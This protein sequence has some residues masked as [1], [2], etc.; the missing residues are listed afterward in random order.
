MFVAG[1]WFQ[2]LW[3]YDFR[4]TEMCIIPYATQMGEISFCAYNTGVG[5]RQIVENMY[6]NATV[7]EWYK[8]HGKHAVYANP[9][10]AVPLPAGA[11]PVSLRIPRD[12]QLDRV[13]AAARPATPPRT[14]GR[15][16]PTDLRRRTGPLKTKRPADESAGLL[17]FVGASARSATR[18]LSP[19]SRRRRCAASA[20][21]GDRWRSSRSC[22]RSPRAAFCGAPTLASAPGCVR[23]TKPMT[24]SSVTFISNPAARA[25]S[26]HAST[27]GILGNGGSNGVGQLTCHP[28]HDVIHSGTSSPP[29]ELGNR[30]VSRS[31]ATA[32]RDDLAEAE[33]APEE[34][35][36]SGAKFVHMKDLQRGIAV[37]ILNA[38]LSRC[39]W[40]NP[41]HVVVSTASRHTVHAHVGR[42]R[43][44]T[45]ARRAR[46]CY[47]GGAAA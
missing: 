43:V 44:P 4:R 14:G 12:G 27:R 37:S 15:A 6:Q 22:R 17:S 46:S 8:E 24:A 41:Q 10:K 45:P 13:D 9:R 38:P 36:G 42:V 16:R 35:Q 19:A 5:W 11:Q 39:Q 18:L 31:V 47:N 20:G 1:M 26:R 29:P 32:G 28:V 3:T 40:L 34:A 23:L 33:A 30:G 7:A 25:R 21:T 2:D